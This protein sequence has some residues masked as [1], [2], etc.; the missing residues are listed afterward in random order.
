MVDI[1][2]QAVIDSSAW[3]GD[4]LKNDTSWIRTLNESEIVEINKAFESVNSQKRH[5]SEIT[6]EIF[7]LP[8]LHKVLFDIQKSIDN[9]R[10]LFLLKGFPVDNYSVED[11]EKIIYGISTHLGEMIVEDTDGTLIDYVTDRGASYDSIAVRGYTTNAELTPHCDSGDVLGLMC[12]RPAKDGGLNSITSSMSIYNEVL[13]NHPEYL[14]PLYNGYH[15]NIRGNGPPGKWVDATKHRVPIYSYYKDRLSCRYNQKAI[16]TAEELEVVPKLTQLEK[17]AINYIAEVSMSPELRFDVMLEP[18]DIL[19]LNNHTVFHT[20]TAFT[21]H[22]E[23]E[24]KRL[25]LRLWI[26]LHEVRELEPLFAEHYNTGPKQG[27]HV[28]SVPHGERED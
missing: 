21:D 19:L 9:N 17:D 20:R 25:L 4:E 1:L 15:F 22:E 2:K 26:N 3:K 13:K 27:P 14:E 18:G 11:L 28:H 23:F 12:I 6:S 16:L 5:F 7:K 10:G 24:N 8:T